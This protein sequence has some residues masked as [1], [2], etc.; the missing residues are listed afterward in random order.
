MSLHA[1]ANLLPV[2]NAHRTISTYL[3]ARILTM[4]EAVAAEAKSRVSS[5]SS[6]TTTT[7][8]TTTTKTTITGTK[9]HAHHAKR[10]PAMIPA[11]AELSS[12]DKKAIK[13]RTG[14]WPVFV[15]PAAATAGQE[16]TKEFGSV[17]RVV[18]DDS[19]K[20]R[21]PSTT[22]EQYYLNLKDAKEIKAREKGS[23][24]AV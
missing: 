6:T 11:D 12:E 21:K 5:V 15:H 19:L 8:T 1:H 20:K 23:H 13:L 18:E 3:P 10:R 17:I 16:T 24:A 9:S 2:T 4:P 7:V 14:R 22:A